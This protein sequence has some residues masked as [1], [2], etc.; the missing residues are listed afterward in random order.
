M[1]A[2]LGHLTHL[3]LVDRRRLFGENLEEALT[4]LPG[5]RSLHITDYSLQVNTSYQGGGA[6][7][8]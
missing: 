6:G 2:A 8:G 4:Q 3:K 7:E 1:L 5:L